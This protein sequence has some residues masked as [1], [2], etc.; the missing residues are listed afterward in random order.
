M[1]VILLQDI[2]GVGKKDQI[3]NASDGY[4]KNF[5]FPKKLGVEAT[6]E[7]LNK[8]AFKQKLA[9]EQRSKQ[10]EEAHLLRKEIESKN[11]KIYVKTGKNGKLFGTITNKEVAVA[12]EE[13]CG[14]KVDKKKITLKE[15]IKSVGNT[16]ADVKL[17]TSVVAKLE[18]SIIEK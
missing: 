14:I 18:M 7:N 15:G 2:K 9:E 17:H 10:L 16:I 4:A 8:L 6:K 11:I 1:K 13:Q 3:I 12:L 5:L